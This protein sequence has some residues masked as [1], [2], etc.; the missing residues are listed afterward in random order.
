VIC[1]VFL[2]CRPALN[3]AWCESSIR[4]WATNGQYLGAFQM[5]AWARSTFGH[6]R[7][8]WEQARAAR[9]YHRVSGWGGWECRPWR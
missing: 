1:Q 2:R 3:V 8:T 9:R 6:G 7:T 5:G 4:P